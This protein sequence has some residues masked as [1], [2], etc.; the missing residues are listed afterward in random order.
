MLNRTHPTVEELKAVAAQIVVSGRVPKDTAIQI[1]TDE[2]HV[3]VKDLDD[4]LIT[5][6]PRIKYRYPTE[7]S[8]YFRNA[9]HERLTEPI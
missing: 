6:I 3:T 9:W 2:N 7:D 8:E 5:R 4:V 1:V